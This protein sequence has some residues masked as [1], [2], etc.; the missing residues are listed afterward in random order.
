MFVQWFGAVGGT[1][2]VR[3]V[4]ATTSDWDFCNP[5]HAQ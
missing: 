3:E 4:Q 2:Y 5:N 1:M